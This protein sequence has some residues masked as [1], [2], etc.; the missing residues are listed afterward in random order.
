MGPSAPLR[1]EKEPGRLALLALTALGVVFGDI[2]T[3]PLYALRVCFDEGHG[4]RLDAGNILGALSLIFWAL[5]LVICTKYLGFILQADNRGE[6]G[7]LALMA[8]ARKPYAHRRGLFRFLTLAG[9]FGAA[10]L[11][12][13]GMITPAISVLSAVEGLEVATPVLHPYV[14]PLTIFLL[15]ALFFFQRRGTAKVGAVFGPIMFLWFLVL[16]VLG[17]RGILLAPEVLAALNPFYG[18]RFLMENRGAGFLALGAVFLVVTGGEALYA[19][20]GHFGRR[21]IRLTWFSLVFPALLLNYFGQGALLIRHPEYVENPFFLLAPPWAV[22]PLVVLATAATIIASQAVISGSFSLT[23]QAIQLGFCPRVAIRHTSSQEIGQIYVPSVN[24]AL[25]VATISLVLGFGNSDNLAAAYGVAV[26]TDMVFATVLFFFLTRGLWKW[27]LGAAVPLAAAL[28][29]ADLAFWGANIVKVPQGGWFPL[30]IAAVVFTLMTTW[31]R[32]RE[33][34]YAR[35]QEQV[36][37]LDLFLA[38][39]ERNP[40]LRVKGSAVYMTGNPQGVPVAL[41]H[42]LMHYHVLHE[43]VVFLTVVTEEEPYVRGED[44]VKVEEVGQGI[45]RITA[46]LG[47]ME[48]PDVPELLKAAARFGLHFDMMQTSFF[49]GRE[50]LIPSSR[51]GMTRWRERLFALMS[52]NAQPA[53]AFFG[54]PVNRVVELGA[55]IEI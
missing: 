31:K 38:D 1:A 55:Q 46:R 22:L 8:L 18:F 9:L 32:G 4:V 50:T 42:N 2:G 26:T 15:V 34:L 43:D 48:T 20:M 11:Y 52:R 24:W 36:L 27:R 40:P 51:P 13:D 5:V 28:L 25:M 12:G 47:F 29:A 30:V 10:L 39:L 33:I 21:P 35:L 3:S 44:R 17:L 41:L 6:G 23:R 49:L 37:P 19:D 45:H 16:A 7:I 14:Q 53:T 54:I